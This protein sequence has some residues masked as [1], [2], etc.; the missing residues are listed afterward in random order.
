MVRE[1]VAFRSEEHASLQSAAQKIAR[2]GAESPKWLKML[3]PMC[4]EFVVCL[5]LLPAATAA[6]S[7]AAQATLPRPSHKRGNRPTVK[8]MKAA[9][10]HLVITMPALPP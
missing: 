4:L 2:T 1:F 3:V 7:P 9:L 8:A 10:S 6:T 5:L